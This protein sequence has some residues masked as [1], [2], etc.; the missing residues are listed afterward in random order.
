MKI[1]HIGGWREELRECAHPFECHEHTHTL[2]RILCV[3]SRRRVRKDQELAQQRLL[4][5][6][7]P[8]WRARL[9][10]VKAQMEDS[11]L[12]VEVAEQEMRKA[13][14]SMRE[15]QHALGL[16][17][18][19]RMHDDLLNALTRAP[20]R[21]FDTTPIGRLLARFSR[22]RVCEC[23]HAVAPSRWVSHIFSSSPLAIS[24]IS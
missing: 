6:E 8:S 7:S 5:V 23:L 9:D 10:A 14:Q 3:L 11:S 13:V 16:K 1:Q 12:K 19:S 24:R 20:L 22:W 4:T 21:F 17:A 18:G 2:Q 15:E